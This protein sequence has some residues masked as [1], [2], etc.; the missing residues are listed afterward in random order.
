MKIEKYS[1]IGDRYNTLD[2]NVTQE[3]LDRWYDGEK[4]QD[5]MPHLTQDEMEF[6][7]SGLLPEEWYP[8][9]MIP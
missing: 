9:F 7:I 6:L 4:M 5:V 2:L 8:D 3:M 1:I